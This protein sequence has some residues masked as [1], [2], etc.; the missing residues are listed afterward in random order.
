MP[1]NLQA[2]LLMTTAMALIAVNDAAVKYVS[3][4]VSVGQVLGIRGGFICVLITT[5]FFVKKQ[6]VFQPD[7][8]QSW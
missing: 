3:E 1:P 4:D 6:R 7:L 2:A 8:L 5:F